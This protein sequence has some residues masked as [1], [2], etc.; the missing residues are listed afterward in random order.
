MEN[1]TPDAVRYEA[2]RHLA[3]THGAR[4]PVVALIVSGAI[5]VVTIITLPHLGGLEPEVK[6]TAMVFVIAVHLVV[7]M[8][9]LALTMRPDGK[10]SD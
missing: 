1:G 10:D 6:V 7:T 2:V 9:A 4:T 8:A 3:S 5:T